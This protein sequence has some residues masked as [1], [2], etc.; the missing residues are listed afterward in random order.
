MTTIL[1]TT[2]NADTG[3]PMVDYLLKEGLHVRAMVRKDVL[4]Q[5]LE[6]TRRHRVSFQ[7]TPTPPN[8]PSND[9]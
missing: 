7:A 3:R 1:V 6:L 9:R 4:R 5:D 2:A 8:N